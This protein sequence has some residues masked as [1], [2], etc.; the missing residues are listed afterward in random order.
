MNRKEMQYL[1]DKHMGLVGV[2]NAL[3]HT[4]GNAGTIDP[5][6]LK[7]SLRAM[8]L[9]H[10]AHPDQLSVFEQVLQ[11]LEEPRWR[12][13]VIEGGQSSSPHPEGPAVD[14]KEPHPG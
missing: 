12:P 10:E 4:L 2:V 6:K 8:A 5:E 11:G 9:I 7:L 13:Q 14:K 1:L 3:I